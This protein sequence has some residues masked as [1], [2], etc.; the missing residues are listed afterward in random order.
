MGFGPSCIAHLV[1]VVYMQINQGVKKV[2]GFH[3]IK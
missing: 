3:V 2:A 1:G